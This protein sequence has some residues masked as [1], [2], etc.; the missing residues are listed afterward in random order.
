M[1]DPHAD[2]RSHAWLASLLVFALVWIVFRPALGAQ[3]LHFDDDQLITANPAFRGLDPEHLAWMFRTGHLGHYQPLTWLS[4]ALEQRAAGLDPRVFHR[5][6]V[7]LHGACAVALLSLA[8]RLLARLG[9]RRTTPAAAAC[10]LLFALHPLRAESVAWVT[11]RR[12]VLS[13]CFFV[14]GLWCWLHWAPG[15]GR[16]ERRRGHGALAA[17]LAVAALG[18]FFASVDL[19]PAERF[20][21][22]G[23][24]LPG[25]AAAALCLVGCAVFAG[26][27]VHWEAEAD[28]TRARAGLWYAAALVCFLLSLLAKAWGI[29]VPALLLVLDVWPLGRLHSAVAARG[30]VWPASR[31][32]A[33]AQLVIEKLPLVVLSL[34]FMA[35][36]AWAQ[37]S[38]VHTMR[39]IAEHTLGERLLQ[40][41]Y[42]LAW[43]PWK[44]LVP[45]GLAAMVE[46]PDSISIAERRF[47]LAAIGVTGV[48]A[49][50]FLARRRTPALLATWVAFA[51]IVSPVLGLAQS[52]PQLVA[53]RYSYL[54]CMP[55][56][57]LV[58]GG[59]AMTHS[60]RLAGLLA[61]AIAVLGVT[62]HAQVGVWRDSTTLWE[63]A[64]DVR[65]RSPFARV[66]LASELQR[67]ASG[68]P[69]PA[70]RR[71]LLERARA[72]L[73]EGYELDRDAHFPSGLA[74]VHLGLASLEF[75]GSAPDAEAARADVERAVELAREALEL[76]HRTGAFTPHYRLIYGIALW[77][78]GRYE[79][80]RGHLE[81]YARA[82]PDDPSGLVALGRAW[83][84]LRGAAAAREPLERAVRID[85]RRADGWQELIGVYEELGDRDRAAD[86]RRRLAA[87]PGG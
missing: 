65:P 62:A 51:V 2:S 32:A 50:L 35:L 77:Q 49:V 60:R 82:M 8:R 23:P 22:T 36:A 18:L 75:S 47:L 25:V 41:A 14:L 48:T 58:G 33:R 38:Q 55:F 12:D 5:T 31:F 71:E 80:A 39:G 59:V 61:A 40:A 64:L 26:R 69:N 84:R 63:H 57:L 15:A 44:T 1:A 85:P 79:D 3:F 70:A 46:L 34:V 76:A 67:Q 20:G 13:G 11:E 72:L 9:M 16:G 24:G 86:A 29:V 81:W 10:A 52:G 6:N 4:Y 73:E 43:Y 83:A 17:L 87:L 37:S 42:G 21:F 7:I 45:G 28:E 56:A 19:S 27:S 30:G 66:M 74:M 53:D 54:S 68:E 78:A